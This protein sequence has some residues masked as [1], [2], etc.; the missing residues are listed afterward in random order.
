MFEFYVVWLGSWNSQLEKN[1]CQQKSVYAFRTE[2]HCTGFGA[3]EGKVK[4]GRTPGQG[5]KGKAA[6]RGF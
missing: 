5:W 4:A 3:G 1:E 6:S 2:A